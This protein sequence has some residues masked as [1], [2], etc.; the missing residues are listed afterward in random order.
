M[1][2]AD[3]G[4]RRRFSGWPAFLLCVGLLLAACSPPVS[5]QSLPTTPSGKYAEVLTF[6]ATAT[7]P[8]PEHVVTVAAD[9]DPAKLM[10]W[11]KTNRAYTAGLAAKLVGPEGFAPRHA[12]LYIPITD[13]QEV[14]REGNVTQVAFLPAGSPMENGFRRGEPREAFRFEPTPG[15]WLLTIEMRTVNNADRNMLKAIR[16]LHIDVLGPKDGDGALTGWVQ[17][18]E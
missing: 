9:I 12:T 7:A 4:H 8:G 2:V 1:L 3:H 6:R 17:V 13:Q 11:S 10:G 5:I 18:P 15:E 14:G 16:T